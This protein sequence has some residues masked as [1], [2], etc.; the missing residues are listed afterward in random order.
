MTPDGDDSAR[1][2]AVLQAFEA[3]RV[4]GNVNADTAI[5]NAVKVLASDKGTQLADL[6]RAG[7]LDTFL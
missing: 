5:W 3:G 4:R 1:T 6:T 2:H 7:A